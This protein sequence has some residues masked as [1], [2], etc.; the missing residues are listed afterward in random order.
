MAARPT[1]RP[2]LDPC[3]VIITDTTRPVGVRSALVVLPGGWGSELEPNYRE[4]GWQ[5]LRRATLKELVKNTVAKM[6]YS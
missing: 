2:V 3:T 1:E 5:T 4:S 6:M